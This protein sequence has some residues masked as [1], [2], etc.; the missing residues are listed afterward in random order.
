MWSKNHMIVSWSA[1]FREKL[2]KTGKKY[3]TF[4]PVEGLFYNHKRQN[5]AYNLNCYGQGG[6][7]LWTT[8]QLEQV[9][10]QHLS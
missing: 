1:W 7:K 6:M 4:H 10:S 3:L 8:E 9:A 2:H 5:I